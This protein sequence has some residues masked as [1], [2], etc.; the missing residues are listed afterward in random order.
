[1]EDRARAAV[2]V[3]VMLWLPQRITRKCCSSSC[4]ESIRSIRH[5]AQKCRA[6]R[7]RHDRLS[8][9]RLCSAPHRCHGDQSLCASML[10][11]GRPPSR[12]PRA[13]GRGQSRVQMRR[14]W[15][16]RSDWSNSGNGGNG[17]RRPRQLCSRPG[18]I[19]LQGK[20]TS[21]SPCRLRQET[22]TARGRPSG[23][24]KQGQKHGRAPR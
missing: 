2:C 18:Q 6:R 11:A 22:R 8:P 15:L 23:V 12:G 4:E 9:P 1:M 21:S 13:C 3:R 24:L 20:P 16:R 17:L 5:R 10:L 19:H 14:R 7:L